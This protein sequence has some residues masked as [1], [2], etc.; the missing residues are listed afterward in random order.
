MGMETPAVQEPR[1][2]WILMG[3]A[4]LQVRAQRSQV[5]GDTQAVEWDPFA[6]SAALILQST[7]MQARREERLKLEAAAISADQT[8]EGGGDIRPADASCAFEDEGFAEAQADE[9]SVGGNSGD[10]SL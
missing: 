1:S 3:A 5:C 6:D 10:P 2:A 9:H 7:E 8:R 4:A